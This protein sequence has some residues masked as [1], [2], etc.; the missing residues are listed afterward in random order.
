MLAAAVFSFAL[1]L[2]FRN[3]S[4]KTLRIDL[5]C[6][7]AIAVVAG[8]D[9]AL[10]FGPHL[11]VPYVSAFKYLY[12]ALPFLCLLAASL[13]DK[14]A[15]LA[16]SAGKRK[17]KLVLAA[18]GLTLLFASIVESLVFL[19]HYELYT[20]IDFKVDYAGNYFPFNV[21]TPV[22]TNFQLWHYFAVALMILSLVSP[23]VWRAI[24]GAF[25][26]K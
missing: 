26:K 16:V 15:L 9:L 4:A 8:V 24:R 19:N 7:G 18:S 12:A 14:G 25:A 17:V 1:T 5:V 21:Y 22:S 2:G 6:V 13:A 23:F 11:L 20:L 3:L 10:V